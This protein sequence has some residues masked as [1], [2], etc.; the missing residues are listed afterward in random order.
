MVGTAVARIVASI[1]TRL[2]V[3][4]SAR[5][6]GPRSERKPTSARLAKVTR[7]QR[8]RRGPLAPNREPTR[9]VAAGP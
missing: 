5:S 9:A 1:A 2:V 6:T 7:P 8:P 4:M 3:V